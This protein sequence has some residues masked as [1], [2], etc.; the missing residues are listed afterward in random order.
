MRML[1]TRLDEPCRKVF[2]ADQT[3]QRADRIGIRDHETGRD[4]LA[5]LQN[6]AIRAA[7][8]NDDVTNL[9]TNPY[10]GTGVSGR[11]GQRLAHG[12][13]PAASGPAWRNRV[14]LAGREPQQHAG[15]SA[16][17]RTEKRP[18]R[19]ARRDGRAERF[20]LEPFADEVGG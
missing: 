4:L 8:A 1:R 17:A 6:D 18:K 20:T 10:L 16:R 3:E 15:A 12:A 2:G 13:D 9:G 14:T 5:R 7:V 19:S 11:A